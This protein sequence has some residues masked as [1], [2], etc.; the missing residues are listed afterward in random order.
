MST[1]TTTPA[2]SAGPSPESPS[3]PSASTDSG[4]WH[5]NRAQTG[6]MN[7]LVGLVVAIGV[8]L[9]VAAA[10]LIPAAQNYAGSNK[11]NLTATQKT[12]AGLVTIFAVLGLAIAFINA[13][14]SAF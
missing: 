2:D 1:E 7:R 8:A 5:D 14:T 13:S 12:I 9:Y 4:I 10:L 6:P 3:G 11:S